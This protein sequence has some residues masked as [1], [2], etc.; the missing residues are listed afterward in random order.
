MTET[1]EF[2]GLR[3]CYRKG[4]EDEVVLRETFEENIFYRDLPYLKLEKRPV[5][6]DIGAHIGTFAIQTATKYP[7][8]TVYA[9]EASHETFSLLEGNVC[10][11]GLTGRVVVVN[12]AVSA[13][14]GEVTLYH[15]LV[16]GNWGHTISKKV[17]DSI[18]IVESTTLSRFMK[19]SRI[20]A[21]DL[22]KSNCEGAEFEIILN[23]SLDDLAR[24]KCAIVLYHCDLVGGSQTVEKLVRRLT[25]A[26]HH[27]FLL[28]QKRDR[29]WII[30]I[31]RKYYSSFWFGL[32]GRIK[33]FIRSS[34]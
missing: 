10:E 11:N 20:E 30:S 19:N 16:D 28:Y 32:L 23:T 8:A 2:S 22:L 17:S 26:G 25:A 9:F 7:K 27:C 29:G 12:K 24:V 1:K 34:L 5:V 33:R 14:D 21:I 31:S 13:K 15:N 6:V 18:E 4:T 3:V